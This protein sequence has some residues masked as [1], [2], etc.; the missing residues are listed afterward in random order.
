M[1]IKLVRGTAIVV[2]AAA[3][4]AAALYHLSYPIQLNRVTL[5]E[6]IKDYYNRGRSAAHSPAV[7]VYDGVSIGKE[8]YY[9][10]ELDGALGSV[11][12]KQGLNGRYKFTRLGCG[13]GSFLDGIIEN[14]GKKYL[15]FGGRDPSAQIARITV[16]MN[17]RTYD[18]YP[19]PAE[20][21]FLLCTEIDRWTQDSHVDRGH[22]SFYDESG[23]DITARYDLSGGGI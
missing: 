1:K 12:L 8:E 6:H 18:L 2:I 21:H 9:L 15:L 5:P 7:L 22:I 16:L 17:G 11:S 10:I 20:D 3:I 4:F 14:D 13:G 23:E 19:G